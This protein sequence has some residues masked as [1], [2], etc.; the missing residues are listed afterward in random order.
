MDHI[1]RRVAKGALAT[2]DRLPSVRACASLLSVSP[3]TVVEAYSRL[4][5]EGEIF[6]RRGSGFY[7]SDRSR[8]RVLANPGA[9][10]EREIDPLWVMRQSIE[11]D[12]PLAMPGCGWLPE[13][14]MP[15]DAIRKGLRTTARGEVSGLVAYTSPLGYLPFR[16]HLERRLNDRG[17]PARA[18][19]IVLT[20]SGTQAIDLLCR[21]LL[22]RGDMVMVDDP[23]YFN[24]LNI[25]RAHEVTVIGIP[26]T[27]TGPD[28]DVMSTVVSTSKPRLYLTSASPHNPTGVTISPVAQH[29]ILKL[30]EA[31]DFL[32]IEDD[33]FA[34]FEPVPT[35]RLAAFDGL[36]RVAYV[37]SF[38]K[39]LSASMRCGF[40]ALPAEWVDSLID[41]RLASTFGGNEVT[42]RLLHDLLT[43]GAYR[44]HLENVRSKLARNYP[45]VLNHLSGSGLKLWTESRAGMF[46]WTE[47]PANLEA[48]EVARYAMK[49]GVLLAPGNVFSAGLRWRS[50][51]RFNIAQSDDEFMYQTLRQAMKHSGSRA[52]SNV[53]DL[54]LLISENWLS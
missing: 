9:H 3:S 12:R 7:I 36:E 39:T 27:P 8:P 24:F 10:L 52:D 2:G 26:Y 29:R 17:I 22:R 44:R 53:A 4:V 19:R 23:C 15:I 25:L 34:D 42:A 20:D 16:N 6:A 54:N 11:A 14:W 40:V 46:F 41:L 13:G 21:L 45:V 47:L 1:R 49:Q 5:A 35:T 31:N 38:S 48:V 51:L 33:V 32:I 37:G 18:D 28:L 43:N 50:F 30:A